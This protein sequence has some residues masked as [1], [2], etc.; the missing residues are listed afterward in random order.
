[1]REKLSGCHKPPFFVAVYLC[2]RQVCFGLKPSD[3]LFALGACH[4]KSAMRVFLLCLLLLVL[5]CTGVCGSQHKAESLAELNGD[6]ALIWGAPSRDLFCVLSI[7]RINQ[8]F[9]TDYLTGLRNHNAKV[10]IVDDAKGF[11]VS[12]PWTS[13]V[14]KVQA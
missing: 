7:R 4:L 6:S 5:L 10:L 9:V 3:S 1:M 11:I 8:F 13:V 12:S 14:E 2:I